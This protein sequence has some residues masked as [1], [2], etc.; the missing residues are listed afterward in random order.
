MTSRKY[1]NIYRK[2]IVNKIEEITDKSVLIEIFNIISLD[3]GND[4]SINVNGIFININILSNK[5]IES[6]NRYL[7]NIEEKPQC[8]TINVQFVDNNPTDISDIFK[9]YEYKFNNNEKSIIKKIL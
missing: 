4:Y 9:N 7:E 3:I 2:K 6:I 5:C 8:K 1:N